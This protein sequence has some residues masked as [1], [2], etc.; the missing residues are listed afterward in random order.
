MEKNLKSNIILC[1][2]PDMS[3]SF[4]VHAKVVPLQG[5]DKKTGYEL[6]FQ[7]FLMKGLINLA[8]AGTQEIFKQHL[9]KKEE[10]PSFSKRYSAYFGE[11][12]TM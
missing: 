9:I 12:T 6:I 5:I 10:Q 1:V 7:I 2:R 11:V 4:G 3:S 8:V